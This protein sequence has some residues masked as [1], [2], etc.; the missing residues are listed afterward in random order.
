MTTRT[1]IHLKQVIQTE[2]T[3]AKRNRICRP[4]FEIDTSLYLPLISRA[5]Q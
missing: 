2:Q 1:Y 4:I 3:S 5:D